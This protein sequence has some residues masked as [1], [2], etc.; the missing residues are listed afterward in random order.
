MTS[1][2]TAE[3]V[4]IAAESARAA[5]VAYNIRFYPLCREAAATV[6]NLPIE[7]VWVSC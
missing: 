5:G 1:A 3:L 4:R 2:E 6:K 7:K